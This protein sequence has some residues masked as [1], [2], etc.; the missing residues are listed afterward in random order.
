MFKWF[1]NAVTF[2]WWDQL[3]LQEGLGDYMKY[4]FADF[5]YQDWRLVSLNILKSF[6]FL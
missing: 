2:K 4:K 6:T 5:A 1:G 3:W